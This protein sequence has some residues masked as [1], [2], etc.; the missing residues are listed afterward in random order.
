MHNKQAIE[1]T[2][3]ILLLLHDVTWTN[4]SNLHIYFWFIE[5]QKEEQN[6]QKKI[7]RHKFD[8]KKNM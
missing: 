3:F 2:L 8:K 1:H 6:I 7:D 5:I 4:E